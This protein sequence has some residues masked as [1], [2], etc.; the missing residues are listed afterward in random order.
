MN[1]LLRTCSPLP[2]DAC[3]I[4]PADVAANRPFRL[5]KLAADEEAV[6]IRG[7][8]QMVR[9]LGCACNEDEY[10]GVEFG[11]TLEKETAVVRKRGE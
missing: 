9:V 8:L 11:S 2:D 6:A 3:I 1:M 4:I 10:L 7:T 5:S